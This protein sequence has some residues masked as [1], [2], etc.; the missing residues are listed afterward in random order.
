[1]T[2]KSTIIFFLNIW[3]PTFFFVYKY[4]H[5]Q[6]KIFIFYLEIYMCKMYTI[7]CLVNTSSNTDSMSITL[8][9]D[10]LSL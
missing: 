8:A 6:T 10:L 7:Y 1:M 5:L 4:D 9:L 3:V 2:K